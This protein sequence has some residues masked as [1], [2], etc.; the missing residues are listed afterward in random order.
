MKGYAPI[1][2]LKDFVN[3]YS[4]YK[5]DTEIAHLLNVSEKDIKAIRKEVIDESDEKLKV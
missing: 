3:I 1:T 5:S 4:S 2:T